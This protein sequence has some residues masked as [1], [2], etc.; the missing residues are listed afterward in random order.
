MNRSRIF[1]GLLLILMVGLGLYSRRL[2]PFLP[3]FINTYLG[4]AIWAAMIFV[5]FAFL[6]NRRKTAVIV[7]AAG[8]YCLLTEC[9]Q[10]YQAAW[11]N[12][13]RGTSLGGLI[14]GYGFLWT[15]LAAYAIGISICAGSEYIAKKPSVR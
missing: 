13:I 15:D 5:G 9:S 3:G 6:F 4:D 8:F 2:S 1:Y 10:L 11:I 7:G 14:L 12:D